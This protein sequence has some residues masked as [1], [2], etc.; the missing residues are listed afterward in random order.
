MFP[1]IVFFE[2]TN[3]E[4]N[5]QHLFGGSNPIQVGMTLVVDHSGRLFTKR[6]PTIK[7][8]TTNCEAGDDENIYITYILY[9]IR[10]C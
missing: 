5:L 1:N 3:W 8:V 6:K 9:D 10:N 2:K 7:D 4:N